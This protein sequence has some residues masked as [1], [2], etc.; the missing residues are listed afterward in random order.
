M[1]DDCAFRLS[2]TRRWRRAGSSAARTGAIVAGSDYEGLGVGRGP[3]LRRH[4]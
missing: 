3:S 2:G 1:V 4:R